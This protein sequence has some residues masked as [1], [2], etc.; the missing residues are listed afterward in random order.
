[1]IDPE[2][3]STQNKPRPYR[4]SKWM[5][6]NWARVHYARKVEPTWFEINRFDLPIAD[7]GAEFEGFRILQIS[8]L[9]CGPKLPHDYLPQVVAAAKAEA[10]D[11][12]VLT[13]DFVHKGF[14]HVEAAADSLQ[15]LTAPHGVF[16]VLGNHDHSIRN[17][18]G[19]RRHR[20]LSKTITDAL[21]S[22][23]VRVL[24]N[25]SQTFRRGD[26]QLHLA[27]VDDLWSRRCDI[28]RALA[29]LNPAT[30]RVLLAHNPRTVERLE[31]HRC[32]VMLS[33]HTHGGQVD[34]PRMGRVALG[35]KA[36]QYAAGLYRYEQ[37]HLYVNKGIGFG[38]RFRYG[39]RPE[40][41]VFQ[42]RRV[43]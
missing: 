23:G 13:G 25:E 6:R 28:G 30:P 20:H 38:W 1:M 21:I 2:H 3:D 9:H 32:D 7:L 27:G 37:T 14:R 5:G 12:V 16:A 4:L 39:V 43:T 24:D 41:A 42:L 17:A 40:V 11:A 10:P 31:G 26:D 22:R 19:I 34:L 33:G 8:D 35:R 15:E 29:G 18:L 36:K